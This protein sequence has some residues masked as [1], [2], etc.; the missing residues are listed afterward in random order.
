MKTWL[1]VVLL[2]AAVLASP[3][4]GASRAARWFLVPGRSVSCEMGFRRPGLHPPTYVYCLAY[5]GGSPERTALSVQMN[6]SARL[7]ICHGCI[8]NAP[9]PD[10][11][12][13]AG[14]SISLGP[15]RCTALWNAVRCIV[16]KTGHG[17]VL[18]LH[19]LKR[20]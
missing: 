7:S 9:T 13:K 4:A 15:F 6:P 3:A 14:H 16:T 19:S 18:R 5:K 20:V 1:A 17:F 2:V 8:G 10:P 11:T 12:L